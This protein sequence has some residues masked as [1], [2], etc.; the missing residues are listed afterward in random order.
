MTRSS[1]FGLDRLVVSYVGKLLIF[2]KPFHFSHFSMIFHGTMIPDVLIF[3]ILCLIHPSV[4][5]IISK[6]KFLNFFNI[7]QTKKWPISLLIALNNTSTFEEFKCIVLSY[8]FRGR[9]SRQLAM[10]GNLSTL[11]WFQSR[12]ITWHFYLLVDLALRGELESLKWAM[13][14]ES[15]FKNGKLLM[16]LILERAAFNGHENILRWAL[17]LQYFEQ[18]YFTTV[19]N[20][21]AAGDQLKIIHWMI[22]NYPSAM[23]LMEETPNA[24]ICYGAICG[25]NIHIIE[26][27]KNYFPNTFWIE[28]FYDNKNNSPCVTKAAE[29]GN[30]QML[31]WLKENGFLLNCEMVTVAAVSSMEN[32]LETLKFLR[33]LNCPW[34]SNICPRAVKFGRFDILLWA[35]SNGCPWQLEDIL[36]AAAWSKVASANPDILQWITDQRFD[37][38]NIHIDLI[39]HDAIEFENFKFVKWAKST[40]V[41]NFWDDRI[42]KKAAA[43]GDLSAL[44]WALEINP[45]SITSEVVY[46]LSV[47]AAAGR[48]LHVLNWLLANYDSYK[49]SIWHPQVCVLAA[50]YGYVDVLQW[51]VAHG[52][53]WSK[54]DCC[55]CAIENKQ[56]KVLIWMKFQ[57]P[58][59]SQYESKY[60][61]GDSRS[62]II[63]STNCFCSC[64]CDFAQWLLLHFFGNEMFEEKFE[65]PYKRPCISR[66]KFG[67]I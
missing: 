32:S 41:P 43:A 14:N 7:Q 34:S 57:A 49:T 50:R 67:D 58:S 44:I 56:L 4:H 11:Q 40:F 46:V 25:N 45:E 48:H 17:E 54:S 62:N 19:L 65:Y 36:E 31:D 37:V 18:K 42:I 5:F 16:E 39:I 35:V 2:L 29:T 52:C 12:E 60:W 53:N 15:N 59:Y 55:I 27:F 63:A 30:I 38:D 51:A 23:E 20:S 10:K 47:N 28:R 9:L 1:R 22:N 21:A 13:L 3:E 33:S 61:Y 64:N 26:W 8:S 6:N 24:N 66:R